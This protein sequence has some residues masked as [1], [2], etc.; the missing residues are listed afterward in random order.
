MH[1]GAGQAAAFV[2]VAVVPPMMLIHELMRHQ[3]LVGVV[4]VSDPSGDGQGSG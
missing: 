3:R 1:A 2:I 4:G